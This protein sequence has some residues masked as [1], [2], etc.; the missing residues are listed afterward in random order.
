[1]KK[2]KRGEEAQKEEDDEKKSTVNRLVSVVR[3]RSNVRWSSRGTSVVNYRTNDWQKR[4]GFIRANYTRA[5]DK[6]F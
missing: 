5:R 2:E 4:R 6:R 1:M 3:T